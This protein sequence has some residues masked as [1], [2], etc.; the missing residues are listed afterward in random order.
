MIGS[1]IGGFCGDPEADLLVK[2]YQVGCFHPFFRG[3]S[4][5]NSLRREPWLFDEKHMNLIGD[6]IKLRYKILPYY[7]T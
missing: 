3:H 7:Y 5:K 2:W 4:S 6:A 1:D